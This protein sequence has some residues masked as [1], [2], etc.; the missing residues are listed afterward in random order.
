MKGTKYTHRSL[1]LGRHGEL[2]IPQIGGDLLHTRREPQQQTHDDDDD[3]AVRSL[4]K[5]AA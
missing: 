3:D 4:P 5:K 1:Q 2:L